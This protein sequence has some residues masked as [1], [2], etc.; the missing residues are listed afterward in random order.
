MEPGSKT[1]IIFHGQCSDGWCAAWVAK[2]V[3]PDAQFYPATHGTKPPDVDNKDVYIFDF[4]YKRNTMLELKSRANSIELY[5]HHKTAAKEL[6]D[7]SFCKF[8]MSKSGATL[9]WD[10]FRN[11]IKGEM[12]WLVSYTEDR[13]LSKFILPFSREINA[14][15]GSYPFDF[16]VW[17]ALERV[18]PTSYITN[19][20]LVHDGRVILRFQERLIEM[21]LHHARK[22]ELDGYKVMA[23]NTAVVHGEVATKLA[24]DNPFGISWYKREDGKIVYSLRS[25]NNGVDVS[26]VAYNHGGGGHARSAGFESTELVLRDL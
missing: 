18:Y 13:D 24:Q 1:L 21:V 11:K 7:L 22:V 10:V 14:A 5:D 16:N 2:K 9:A 4:A 20:S 26:A 12:P 8:D 6:G 19:S 17:D 23:A 25:R 15:L 3:F